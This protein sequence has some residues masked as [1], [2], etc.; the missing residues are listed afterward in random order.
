M[1][2]S[3]KPAGNGSA[4]RKP[5]ALPARTLGRE[6]GRAEER[7]EGFVLTP[8]HRGEEPASP[9]AMVSGSTPYHKKAQEMQ[10]ALEMMEVQALDEWEP[11]SRAS[12]PRLDGDHD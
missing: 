12:H 7:G 10:R 5:C 8:F 11:P 4:P 9:G 3:S 6:R 1:P 2:S